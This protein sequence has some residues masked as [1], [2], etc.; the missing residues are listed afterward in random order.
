MIIA[1][2]F[3]GT[4]VTH[5]YPAIGKPVEDAIPV[6][7]QL[8]SKGHKIILY[9]MRSDRFL[10]DAV[11]YLKRAGINLFGVNHNPEQ[12]RWTNSPKVYAQLYIDDAALGCPL[13]YPEDSLTP[14]YVDWD[15]VQK[16]L[17]KKGIL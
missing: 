14:P 11:E 13:I 12:D 10:S 9:T 16:E 15:S 3:D 6:I 17:Q 7:Q 1:I 5:E 2:D 8:I 4:I